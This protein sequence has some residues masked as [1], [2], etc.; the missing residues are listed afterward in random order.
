MGSQLTP[1][2]VEDFAPLQKRHKNAVQ[3]CCRPAARLHP[4]GLVRRP[5][6][7]D[8]DLLWGRLP[9]MLPGEEHMW[10]SLRLMQ[11]GF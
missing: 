2:P 7:G 9:C 1:A 4:A 11:S 8:G 5:G 10:T 3:A 6:R